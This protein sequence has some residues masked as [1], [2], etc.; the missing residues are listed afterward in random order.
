MSSWDWR[1]DEPDHY[2]APRPPFLPNQ[3]P[4]HWSLRLMAVICVVALPWTL[5]LTVTHLLIGLP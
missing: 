2:D 1:E 5:L 3:Q 4:L